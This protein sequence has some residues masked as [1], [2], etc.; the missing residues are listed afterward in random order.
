MNK[1]TYSAILFFKPGTLRPRKYK[2]ISSVE[3]F[4][5][6]VCIKDDC[7]YINLYDQNTGN[8]EKRIWIKDFR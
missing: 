3:R 5:K 8:F 4:I 7:Y 2:N 6:N 1:K